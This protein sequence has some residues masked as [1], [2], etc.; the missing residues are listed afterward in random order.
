MIT[1]TEATQL[2]GQLQF[3]PRVIEISIHESLNFIL[4]EDIIADLDQPP[5]NR[6]AMDG[7]AIQSKNLGEKAEFEITDI[8]PA[9]SPSLTLKDGMYAI[10]VMTGAVLPNNSNLVVR[11]EDLEI[12]DNKAKLKVHSNLSSN[13]QSRGS[14]YKKGD[15]VVYKNTTINPA[16]ISVLASAGKEKVKIYDGPRICILSTGDELVDIG[17]FPQEHQ[18]RWSNGI[19]L[20]SLLQK[21]NF[22]KVDLVKLKDDVTLLKNEIKNKLSDYDIL[23]LT[24]GVSAGKFDFIPSLLKQNG[25]KEIFH[26]VAQRPGKPLWFGTFEN[27]CHVFGLPG[28]P[29]SCLMNLRKYVIPWLSNQSTSYDIK[30]NHE[31]F[32]NKPLTF[33]CPVKIKMDQAQFFAEQI[34]GNGSGDFFHLIE[35]D[36]FVELENSKGPFLKNQIVRFYPWGNLF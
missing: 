16:V 32:F 2:V 25:V 15:I 28:N 7:I 12:K 9:G 4:A 8:L 35:S 36:G 11:Y 27:R 23:I 3:T 20:K 13:V 26:K 21:Y 5:F 34:K 31:I 17:E 29:V 30:L 14:D 24:G 18:I 33:F 22:N 1:V 19:T 6:V 10:E